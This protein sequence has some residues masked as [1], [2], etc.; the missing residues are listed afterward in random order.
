MTMFWFKNWSIMNLDTTGTI[1]NVVS[2]HYDNMLLNEANALQV[3]TLFGRK[4]VNIPSG[5]GKKVTFIRLSMPS[6]V[7][8]PN[9]EGVDPAALNWGK[10]EITGA[11]EEYVAIM[12][13][14]SLKFE[15]EVD[16]VT[17]GLAMSFTQHAGRSRDLICREVINGGTGVYRGG[18][19]A[20]RNLIVTGF[21]KT[22]AQ[23]IQQILSRN[24]AKQFTNF[25]SADNGAVVPLK[26]AFVAIVHTDLEMDIQNTLGTDFKP[27]EKYA[28]NT[29]L[30]PG[31]FGAFEKIRFVS[32]SDAKVWQDAGGAVGSTGLYSTTGTNI[33]V[34]SMLVLG[35][36]A[37]GTVALKE[38]A[39]AKMILK[40]PEQA[41]SKADLYSSMAWK[42][43]VKD[44]IL[45][46]NF[47]QR[48]EIGRSA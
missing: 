30:L 12:V 39:N 23:K 28:Q 13:N 29:T 24:N 31:E 27:V 20:A 42:L 46:D 47:M 10:A 19:V 44:V 6:P 17:N 9:S 3:H 22:E 37:F 40:S 33:D 2:D 48:Y 26:P 4:S 8:T 21:N 32:T 1:P 38:G 43:Y 35:V 36:E 5:K 25:V 15:T 16:A 18:A 7:T 41:G 14:S 45:N 34:Y 11:V